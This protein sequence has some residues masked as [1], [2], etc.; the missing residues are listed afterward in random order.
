MDSLFNI[1]VMGILGSFAGGFLGAVF[2]GLVAFVFTGI[3]IIVGIA[4][5]IGSGDSAFLDLIGLGPVF[6]PHISFAGGV[7]AAAYASH[8]GWLA[9]GRDIVTPLVSLSR[10]SVLMVG[11]AFGLGGYLVQS[12]LAGIEGIGAN[13]DSVALTVVLSALAARLMFSK[14]G[15]I[16]QH[17]EGKHGL[18]RFKTSEQHSWLA[19][20]DTF[21]MTMILG[22]FVGAM[23]AWSALEL[24]KAYPDAP[25]VIFLGFAISAISLLFLAMNVLVPATHH[26]TLVSA[27]AVSLF[28]GVVP[29][30][31]ALV[32]IGAIS[33]LCASVLGQLFARFWLIRADTHIDPP[34]SAIWPMT[35]ALILISLVVS[36]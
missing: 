16:G 29:N 15:I 7:A 28:I 12:I 3:A 13:T 9:N 36:K 25:G 11:G 35:T 2:G 10:P 14:C 30:D 26:I 18:D 21:P 22:L 4:I 27:V 33:G 24:L 34:A 17:C 31:V 20:Q 23:S 1:S 6:G 5:I 19:Y 32:T 8:K